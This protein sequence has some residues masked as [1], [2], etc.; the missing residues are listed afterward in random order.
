MVCGTFTIKKVPADQVDE[1]KELFE[2]ND[3]PPISVTAS[4]AP[5]VIVPVVDPDP[6]PRSVV[7]LCRV[8]FRENPAA[9][10]SALG[11]R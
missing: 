7:P 1:T 4:P 11:S 3:P 8:M 6:V 5:M 9:S 2:A 10:S